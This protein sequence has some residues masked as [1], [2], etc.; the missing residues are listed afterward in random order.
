[1]NL[2]VTL[3]SNYIYPLCVMLRS[4]MATNP[5]SKFDVYVGHSSLTD[6]DFEKINSSV[7]E[8]TTIH[9]VEIDKTLFDNAPVLSRISKETYYRLLLESFLPDDVD[10]I[11]YIDPDTVIINKIDDFYNIDFKGNVIAAA[12]HTYGVVEATNRLR[13]GLKNDTH[14]INAGILMIDVDAWRNMITTNEIINFIS[15]NV[16][17]L[18]LG[19]QDA[20]NIIFEDKI[21]YV[22]E[23]IY[24]LDEKTYS[25]YRFFRKISMDWVEKNT[26]IIHYNGGQKP[27][28]GKVYRGKL[29]GYF[30]KFK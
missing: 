20:I 17:K 4:L 19:D 15:K 2:L 25:H 3:D 9:A 7:N 12:P 1:M 8:N 11:L 18:K 23:R 6:E 30:E 22:D 26:V 21:L 5:T 16:K 14:Y 29:G 27:W 24:N 28:S 10:R 13:L